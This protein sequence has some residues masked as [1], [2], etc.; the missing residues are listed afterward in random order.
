MASLLARSAA[1]LAPAREG[2]AS[3]AVRQNARLSGIAV[4]AALAACGAPVTACAQGGKLEARYVVTLAGI[5]IGKGG[6]S[7][8]IAD[9]HYDASAT[10]MTTGLMHVLTEGEGTTTVHGTLAAGKVLNAIYVSVIKSRKHRDEVHVT[11]DKGDV[12]DSRADPPP[13]NPGERVPIGEADLHN[14]S[15]PMTASLLVVPGDGNPVAAAACKRKMAMFDGRLRYDLE[16][17]FKRMDTVKAEKGY[18]GPAVVCAVYF[19]PVG[20]HI[21]SRATIRYLTKQRNMEVWLAPIAGTRVLVPF[22]AQGP[23]PIGQ[24][25]MTATEFV[26]TAAPAPAS[27]NGRKGP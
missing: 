26:S 22:R 23:T 16:L 9:T 1:D 2:G 11:L 13:D 21:P 19:T 25:V 17:A 8:D 24:A 20:G 3:L 14:V 15:D 5:P 4:A 6:W 7:I 18:A 10:G 12:K 27:A